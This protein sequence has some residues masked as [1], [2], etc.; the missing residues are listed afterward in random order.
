MQSTPGIS[1]F[2]SQA[3]GV[4]IAILAVLLVMSLAS[5]NRR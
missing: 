1:H 4:A 2:L 3:D 5:W